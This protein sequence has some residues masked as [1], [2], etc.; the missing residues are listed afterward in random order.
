VTDALTSVIGF[1]GLYGPNATGP[2]GDTWIYGMDMKWKWRPVNN[3]RGWPF[4]LWQTEIMRR[5][6]TTDRFVDDSTPDEII[7][8]PGRTLHDWGVYTQLLY[9]FQYGWVAGLRYEYAGGSG[10][11]TGGRKNDPFRANRHRVSPLLAWHPTEYSRIRLQYNFDHAAHLAGGK[12]AHSVWLGLEIMYGAHA[13][14]T[15]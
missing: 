4:L 10:E 8:L 11:S 15:Y 9:G 6:F 14:H 5:D 7:T 13:A 3:F 12:D 2:N 1:S